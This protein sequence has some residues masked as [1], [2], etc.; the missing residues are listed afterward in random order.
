LLVLALDYEE[1]D[2]NGFTIPSNPGASFSS[3]RFRTPVTRA[4]PAADFA[5]CRSLKIKG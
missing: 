2:E 4:E 5:G 3:S 1:E